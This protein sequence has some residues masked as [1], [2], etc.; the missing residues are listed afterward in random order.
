VTAV[1]CPANIAART[2]TGET[3]PEVARKTFRAIL[4]REPDDDEND[5]IYAQY[6]SSFRKTSSY[7]RILE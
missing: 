1:R 6:S 7:R 3:D 2:S 5:R 4:E